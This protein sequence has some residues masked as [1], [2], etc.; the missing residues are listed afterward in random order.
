MHGST[1]RYLEEDGSPPMIV[2]WTD[3]DAFVT[4]D[5][6]LTA[7]GT[8]SAEIRYACNGDASGSRYG[9]GICG[10]GRT[11]GTGVEHRRLGN[12]CHSGC[13]SGDSVFPPAAAG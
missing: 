11:P 10:R 13:D 2:D 6:V 9:V 4:W 5:V 1:I 3:Q 7:G 8:Y 12:L